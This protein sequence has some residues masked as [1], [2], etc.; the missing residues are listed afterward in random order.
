MMNTSPS[1]PTLRLSPSRSFSLWSLL[2]FSSSP[3]SYSAAAAAAATPTSAAAKMSATSSS[4]CPL[5]YK[6]HKPTIVSLFGSALFL[7]VAY[8]LTLSL[9]KS[10]CELLFSGCGKGKNTRDARGSLLGSTEA[11]A[12]CIRR[13]RIVL[14]SHP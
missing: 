12:N 11:E 10:G 14:C 4:S 5:P 2:P 13:G 1:S 6:Y 9:L 3:S 8:S 7:W